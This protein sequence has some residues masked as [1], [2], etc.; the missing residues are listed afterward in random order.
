MSSIRLYTSAISLMAQTS[1][2]L[3]NGSSFESSR[4]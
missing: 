1:G 4:V 2:G 3:F